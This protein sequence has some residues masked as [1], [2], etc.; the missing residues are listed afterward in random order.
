MKRGDNFCGGVGAMTGPP[1][2]GVCWG[3]LSGRVPSAFS[4]PSHRSVFHAPAG[5]P[6]MAWT[7]AV[8]TVPSDVA[9]SA[10]VWQVAGGG[11]PS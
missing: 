1:R 3:P 4:V 8:F 2:V 9:F 10:E 5:G 11:A 6:F 7:G